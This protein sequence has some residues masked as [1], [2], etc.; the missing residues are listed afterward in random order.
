MPSCALQECQWW[1]P[2]EQSRGGAGNRVTEEK[3]PL[4]AP[5]HLVMATARVGVGLLHSPA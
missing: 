5:D 4:P 3:G 1:H 2:V